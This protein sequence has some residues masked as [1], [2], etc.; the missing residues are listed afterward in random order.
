[1]KEVIHYR[2]HGSTC[3]VCCMLMLLEYYG[4]I[5]KVIKYDESRLFKKLKSSYMEGTPFSAAAWY[6]AKEGLMCE[7]IHSQE[8][9]FKNDNYIDDETYDCLMD[10]YLKWCEY[11]INKGVIIN[12]GV[13]ISCYLLKEKIDCGN[14]I[15]LAGMVGK[16]LHAILIEG[17]NDES[18]VVC[19]PLK[20][21]KELVKYNQIE[22]FMNTPLGKWCICV[23]KK[24]Q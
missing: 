4:V 2:Q 13:D 10:E 18:F 15:I 11:S 24:H 3:V 1:M 14:K 8:K 6:L 21:E 7:L 17:Y 5:S 22:E 9:V 19:D 23:K 20:K 12:N 16:I